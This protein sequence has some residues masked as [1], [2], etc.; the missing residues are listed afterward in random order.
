MPN[1]SELERLGTSSPPTAE[2]VKPGRQ[3]SEFWAVLVLNLVTMAAAAGI[4][5][6]ADIDDVS[7]RI[8]AIIGAVVLLVGNAVAAV[9]YIKSRHSLKSEAMAHDAIVKQQEVIVRQQEASVEASKVIAQ[10]VAAA[11]VPEVKS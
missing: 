7:T 1:P 4:I 10:A 5:P 9:Y 2:G 3:T 6:V 8:T 11:S